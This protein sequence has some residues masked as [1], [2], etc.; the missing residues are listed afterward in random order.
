MYQASTLSSPY[1]NKG[2][3]KYQ[4]QGGRKKAYVLD[5][6][7]KSHNKGGAHRSATLQNRK[8]L[9]HGERSGGP[10][11]VSAQAFMVGGGGAGD[12]GVNPVELIE[13]A[14]Y[15]VGHGI[16][17]F[18]MFYCTL[19]WAFYRDLR[20]KSE[21]ASAKK[22]ESDKQKGSSTKTEDR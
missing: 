6:R 20:K 22:K 1:H 19:N 15:V 11:Y 14:S 5:T 21:I 7:R 3:E 17:L 4:F 18:T 16:I 12:G 10:G 2:K 9:H 13:T 8:Q